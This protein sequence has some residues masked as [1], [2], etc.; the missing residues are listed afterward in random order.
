MDVW[1][2][3]GKPGGSLEGELDKLLNR[4]R[5]QTSMRSFA[6]P[7]Y[8]LEDE[9]SREKLWSRLVVKADLIR[10]SLSRFHFLF[11]FSHRV[12]QNR[13]AL[14]WALSGSGGAGLED[15]Y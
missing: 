5:E 8:E 3:R 11:R 2:E 1:R 10:V 4:P 15:G 14:T 6:L 13:R 7:V 12:A 9:G